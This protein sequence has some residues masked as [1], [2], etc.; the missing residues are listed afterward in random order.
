MC[1][2]RRLE[3]QKGGARSTTIACRYVEFVCCHYAQFWITYLPPPLMSDYCGLDRGRRRLAVLYVSDRARGDQNQHEHDQQRQ[4][5]PRKFDLVT[6]V[7]LR[8][9]T[10][11]I[12]GAV[13]KANDR[14][15]EQTGDD[16]EDRPADG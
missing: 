15:D 5:G 13:S 3:L 16:D 1:D 7:D 6:A 8:R 14:I 11:F 12:S 4:D 9:L 2:V 10:Q